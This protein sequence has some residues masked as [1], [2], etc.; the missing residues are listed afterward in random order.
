MNRMLTLV[1]GLAAVGAAYATA[2]WPAVP[3]AHGGDANRRGRAPFAHAQVAPALPDADAAAIAQAAADAVADAAAAD[4][5]AQAA[6]EAAAAAA[7]AT[8]PEPAAPPPEP[9]I[10][11]IT[12]VTLSVVENSI[13]PPFK[14]QG[15]VRLQLDMEGIIYWVTARNRTEMD[16]QR[17]V[18]KNIGSAANRDRPLLILPDEFTNWQYVKDLLATADRAGTASVYLGVADIENKTTLRLLQ[19]L[20][21]APSDT[22]NDGDFVIHVKEGDGCP[23]VQINGEDIETFP[24]DLNRAWGAGKKAHPDADTSF[25]PNSPVVLDAHRFTPAGYVA[26]V[27]GVLRGLGI[28]CERF[29]GSTTYAGRKRK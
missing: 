22:A 18:F 27:I 28:E 13:L 25:S 16:S 11:S 24:D 6:V 23:A 5:T 26:Q 7:A 8:Q 29:V 15:T 1:G 14:V 19:I 20:P 3:V 4:A 17:Q 2:G 21:S 10:V 12:D 9:D